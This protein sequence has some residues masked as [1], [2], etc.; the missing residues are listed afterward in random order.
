[1]SFNTTGVDVLRNLVSVERC[2]KLAEELDAINRAGLTVK[3]DMCPISDSIYRADN[4]EKLALELL[5]TV[6]K[7]TGLQLL[8]TYSYSRIYRTGEV[9]KPH[10]DREACEISL[11]INLDQEGENWPIYMADPTPQAEGVTKLVTEKDTF[12]VKNIKECY[13]LPGDAVLYRGCEKIHWRVK[14][15][16]IKQTQ[17]FIHYVD[18]NGPNKDYKHDAKVKSVTLKDIKLI[19]QTASDTATDNFIKQLMN[20]CEDKAAQGAKFCIFELQPF[21]SLT[22]LINKLSNTDLVVTSSDIP[23]TIIVSWH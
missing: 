20:I 2:K 19:S 4:I 21:I 15:K 11:T 10:L 14:Y 13:L 16:G 7:A 6:E 17:V 5:P 8:P 18:A 1:M 3:D 12:Y 9:L 23:N 22:K